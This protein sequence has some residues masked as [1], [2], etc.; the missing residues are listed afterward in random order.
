MPEYAVILV[1]APSAEEAESLATLLL[2]RRLIACANLIPGVTSLF[3]WESR[4]DRA[5]EVLLLMKTRRDLVPQL[6]QAVVEAH[7]YE[8]CEVL[9]LPVIAGSEAYLKWIDENVGN[10]EP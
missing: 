5:E 3:W 9:A 1:T 4:L 10:R 2:E 6:T 7:S 8:V